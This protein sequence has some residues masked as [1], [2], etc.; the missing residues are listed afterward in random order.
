MYT[1][2]IG[3]VVALY[4]TLAVS[5]IEAPDERQEMTPPEERPLSSACPRC[6]DE[7]LSGLLSQPP[8]TP[9]RRSLPR[10]NGPFGPVSRETLRQRRF[11]P[12]R[13]WGQVSDYPITQKLAVPSP[14]KAPDP[15]L[16]EPNPV[17]DVRCPMTSSRRLQ[18]GGRGYRPGYNGS[19]SG[20]PGQ[21]ASVR[22]Q[23]PSM[24]VSRTQVREQH[25]PALPTGASPGAPRSMCGRSTPSLRTGP[26]TRPTGWSATAT[27][28]GPASA[29]MSSTGWTMRTT[30]SKAWTTPSGKWSA[31]TPARTK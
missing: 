5:I 25:S 29:T 14:R 13:T 23:I 19:E 22:A 18:R 10:V 26:A 12:V 30:G 9:E 7:K 28:W 2:M 1:M 21:S 3:A 20:L 6:T 17:F 24:S 15:T 4:I 8:A 27:A 11:K 31:P 16:I